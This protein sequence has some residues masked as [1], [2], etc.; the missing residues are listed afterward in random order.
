MWDK[1]KYQKK[2]EEGIWG[3]EKDPDRVGYCKS[4]GREEQEQEQEQEDDFTSRLLG[5]YVSHNPLH[6]SLSA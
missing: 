1:E 4:W 2:H 6:L 3:K 5:L